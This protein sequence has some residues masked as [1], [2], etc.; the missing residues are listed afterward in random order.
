MVVAGFVDSV[1]IVEDP[2]NISIEPRV[3]VE[4]CRVI[5]VKELHEVRFMYIDKRQ[6]PMS[7][8]ISITVT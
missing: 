8:M 3:F 2:A 4:R 6:D 1:D 5:P 7:C